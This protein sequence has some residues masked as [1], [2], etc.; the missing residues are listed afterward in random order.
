MLK[1]RGS[2]SAVICQMSNYQ[3]L[4]VNP[5]FYIL[6]NEAGNVHVT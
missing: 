5:G 2:K 6:I 4:K 1:V 3:I